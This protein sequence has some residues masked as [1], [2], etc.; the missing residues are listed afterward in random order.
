[1]KLF[2]RFENL[3]KNTPK[4]FHQPAGWRAAL[5]RTLTAQ[6]P[7][8]MNEAALQDIVDLIP[9]VGDAI[10]APKILTNKGNRMNQLKDWAIG[11]IPVVGD[12]ADLF[13]ASDTNMKQLSIPKEKQKKGT[14]ETIFTGAVFSNATEK[15][16]GGVNRPIW[17]D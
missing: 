10:S 5:I 11:V 1:M 6:P 13:I 15:Y 3:V 16:L 4:A 17:H 9:V 12:V 2:S 14:L 8:N 7:K